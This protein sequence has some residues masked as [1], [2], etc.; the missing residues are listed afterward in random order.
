[1]ISFFRFGW[2]DYFQKNNFFI[3]VNQF[4]FGVLFLHSRQIA[5]ELFKS[6]SF[7]REDRVLDLGCGDG[8]FSNWVAY[9]TEVVVLGID[10]LKQR[11]NKAN[12]TSSMYELS[13]KFMHT[14]IESTIFPKSG[15]TKVLLIDTLEH[16]KE[17]QKLIQRTIGWLSNGGHLFISVPKSKQKRW[18]WKENPD[19]FAYG[20]DKH[21]KVGYSSNEL[22]TLL[23]SNGFTQIQVKETF[24]FIYQILW[25]LTEPIRKSFPNLYRFLFPIFYLF[26]ILDRK[27][28]I[29]QGNGL[30]V[31][32]KK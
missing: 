29:G 16:I 14:E 1:M 13:S 2:I 19:F 26:A 24:Y 6:V 32:A 15:F 9:K 3:K 28:K 21:E 7:T 17:P 27:V 25:E 5:Y 12:A 8:T 18:F 22:S 23:Y 20:K 31:I 4:L 11:I 30:L 10:R